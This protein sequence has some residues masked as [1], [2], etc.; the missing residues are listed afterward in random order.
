LR[1]FGF[2][3]GASS[4]GKRSLPAVRVERHLGKLLLETTVHDRVANKSLI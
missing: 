3:A 4:T 1:A 2:L